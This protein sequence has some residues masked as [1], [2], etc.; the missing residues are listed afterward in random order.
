MLVGDQDSGTR[1][2]LH[3]V[4]LASDGQTPEAQLASSWALSLPRSPYRGLPKVL[5]HE[6]RAALWHWLFLVKEQEA[7]PAWG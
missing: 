4:G 3:T 2:S 1:Q 6:D 5:G 7:E